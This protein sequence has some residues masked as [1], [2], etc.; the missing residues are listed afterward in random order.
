MKCITVFVQVKTTSPKKYC[1]RPNIG[2]IKPKSTYDFTVTMQAQKSAPTDLQCKDKFLIQSTIAPFG[3]TEEAITPDMFAKDSGKYVEE[4]KLKVLLTSPSHSPVLSPVNG[5]PKLEQACLSKPEEEKLSTGVENR[6]PRP[7]MSLFNEKVA[8]GTEVSTPTKPVE[9]VQFPGNH[10]KLNSDDGVV[11]RP[12]YDVEETRKI[13]LREIEELKSKLKTLDSELIQ[14]NS[15]IKKV[16]EEKT[17]AIQENETLKK[18]LVTMR[19][20]VGARSIERGFPPLFVCM[21]AIISLTLGF[22]LHG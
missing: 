5:V 13:L 21:V 7:A 14:A 16:A 9:N 8:R 1:V 2:V 11:A 15:N 20:K 22:L 12:L 4:C 3:S 17:G 6:F 10:V 19:R 18:E